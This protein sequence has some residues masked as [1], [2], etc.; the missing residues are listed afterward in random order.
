MAGLERRAA[1]ECVPALGWVAP[2]FVTFLKAAWMPSIAEE[3]ATETSTA[4]RLATAERRCGF[5]AI[6]FWLMDL[7][8]HDAGRIARTEGGPP[9]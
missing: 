2:T 4:R 6:S 9:A 5:E 1:T 3:L 8:Y 7:V